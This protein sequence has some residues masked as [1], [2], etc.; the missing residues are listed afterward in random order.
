MRI[1]S[2]AF[3]F[4]LSVTA[5]FA[6]NDYKFMDEDGNEVVFP[7]EVPVY[8]AKNPG[9]WED[10]ESIHAPEVISYLRKQG[11]EDVRILTI[12]LLHPM[13]EGE[14]GRIQAIYIFDKDH[15]VIGYHP[16]KPG[17]GKAEAEIWINGIINY[18]QIYVHCSRHGMWQTEERF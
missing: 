10:L 15:Y 9:P 8:S 14:K 1:A 12:K 16:F 7:A 13:K 4:F 17:E 11:L 6:Q 2:A 18:V 3:A 5:A